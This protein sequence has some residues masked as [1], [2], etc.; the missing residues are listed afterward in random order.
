[1]TDETRTYAGV[2]LTGKMFLYKQ[3]EPLTPE[4]HGELGLT[5]PARPFDHVKSER[6]I[7]LTVAEFV[8]AQRHYPIVFL[9]MDDPVP[10][11]IVGVN[12]NEN[13]FVDENGMWDPLSY[14]PAYLRC[15][16]FTLA[17]HGQDEKPVAVIVDRAAEAVSEDAE[18]PFFVDGEVSPQTKQMIDF[19]AAYQ[20]E[21]RRTADFCKRLIEL[22]L[23]TLQKASY[24][25]EGHAEPIP[26]PD[27]IS[28][29]LDKLNELPADTI[30]DLHRNGFLA[31]IY[32]QHYS[33][34]N[35]RYLITRHELNERKSV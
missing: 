20:R 31:S 11:A 4:E 22:D 29:D 28:I 32:V 34:E 8:N 16:P 5:P 19:C 15:Y 27:H 7:P 18:Y 25:N 30:V 23:L 21:R 13:L 12:E 3:P 9:S 33:R 10:L 35:W 14:V 24:S 26:L 17:L 6:A 2:H 1:M